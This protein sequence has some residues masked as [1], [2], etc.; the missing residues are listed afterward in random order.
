[1]LKMTSHLGNHRKI[2][3]PGEHE[4][5]VEVARMERPSSDKIR[6]E[7]PQTCPQFAHDSSAGKNCHKPDKPPISHFFP[8]SFHQRLKTVKKETSRVAWRRQEA[9]GGDHNIKNGD[10]A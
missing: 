9:T 5:A 10:S 3:Q 8:I 7:R 6:V 1:M 2:S 4:R